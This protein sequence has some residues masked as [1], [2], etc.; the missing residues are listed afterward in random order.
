[1]DL[2]EAIKERRSVRKFNPDPVD[3]G[4][5][6]KL[7]DAARMAP[8]WSNYQCWRF[9]VVR[10]EDKREN[11]SRSLPE[12]NPAAKGLVQAP[13]VIVLCAD[14]SESGKQ[15]GKDYYLLDAGLALEQLVLAAHA[16]GLGTC[17]IAWFD[18]E[19]V[20]KVCSIPEDY[21]VVALTPLGVPQKQPSVKPRKDIS[22]IAYREEWGQ[23]F[24]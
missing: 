7:L 5:I 6:E 3:D 23:S 14:P 21:R 8:S 4:L 19:S 18:E 9:L 11:L 2:Y 1:M 10:D 13:V 15:D 17:W 24:K 12:N 16:E 22:E 20:K